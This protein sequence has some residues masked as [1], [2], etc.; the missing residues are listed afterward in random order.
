MRYLGGASRST[1]KREWTPCPQGGG[2]KS[3]VPAGHGAGSGGRD[4]FGD[5]PVSKAQGGWAGVGRVCLSKSRALVGGDV[6]PAELHAESKH[7][8]R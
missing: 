3:G 2:I 5:S 4:G 6:L 8:P 1:G 7:P